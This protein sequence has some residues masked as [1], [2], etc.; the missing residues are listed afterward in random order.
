MFPDHTDQLVQAL[1]RSATDLASRRSL[2]AVELTL[3][4]IVEAAVATVPGADAGGVSM[5]EATRVGSRVPT[6][7]AIGLLDDLQG[8]LGEG[9]CVTAVESPPDDGIVSATDLAGAA[10]SERWPRFAPAAVAHGYRSMVSTH[11]TTEGDVRAA[12]NL[13]SHEPHAFDDNARTLAGLFGAQSTLRLYGATHAAHMEKALGSR[14][15][16]GRA[17]GILIERFDL[18]DE[19]AFQMLVRTSQE[20]NLKLTDVALWLASPEGRRS[21]SRG[22][23]DTG[24]AD[25]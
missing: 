10:D 11:L 5:A 25:R 17:K 18:D 9:P 15:L 22:G 8:E 23:T 7:T 16:I 2:R 20:T 6:T 14:D 12:L 19:D 3:G 24:T 1:R 13:Y 21:R 4:E